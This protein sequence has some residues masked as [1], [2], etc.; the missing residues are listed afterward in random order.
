[1]RSGMWAA[2]ALAVAASATPSWGVGVPVG[3]ARPLGVHS[4]Q[5]M[6]S[7]NPELRSLVALRGWPDWAEEVEV[8]SR[9]P[10]DSH[11]VRIYY[12]RLNRRIAFSN[13][14]ILGAPDI[15]LK[16]DE[17]PIDPEK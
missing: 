8:N 4:L 16:M 11:E 12:M 10:L 17:S 1:M 2:V 6:M 3:P 13:A 5:L 14:Y 9:L 7:Y 15:G